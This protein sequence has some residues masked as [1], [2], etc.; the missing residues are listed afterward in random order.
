MEI[1]ESLAVVSAGVF[2]LVGLLAGVWKY[3]QILVS[4]NGRAHPYIDICHRASLLYAF[5]AILL[6]KFVEISQLPTIIEVLAAGAILFY[7]AI[8]ISTYLI[9]G[10][11]RDT[12]NQIRPPFHIGKMKLSPNMISLHMWMLIIAEIGGF[13]V[14]FYGVIVAI[15]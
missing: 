7:F 15:F 5:A 8:A 2:F 6:A 1:A 14:L 11:L 4:E 12:E 13:L 10:L 3:K 9:H